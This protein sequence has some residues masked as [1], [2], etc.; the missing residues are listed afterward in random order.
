MACHLADDLRDGQR[1]QDWTR[2]LDGLCSQVVCRR[3]LAGPTASS[4]LVPASLQ[5][6]KK[7]TKPGKPSICER[8]VLLFKINLVFAR[9][10]L[11]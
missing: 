5:S 3:L 11:S 2:G 6:S 1:Q 7:E 4:S 8:N 10:S 9:F